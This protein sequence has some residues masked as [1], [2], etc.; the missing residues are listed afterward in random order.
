MMMMMMMLTMM[1]FEPQA[2]GVRGSTYSRSM[3]CNG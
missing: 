2:E 3:G 1:L